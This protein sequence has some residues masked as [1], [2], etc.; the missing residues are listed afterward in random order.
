MSDKKNDDYVVPMPGQ[1]YE[2]K[3]APSEASSQ[4]PMS[5]HSDRPSP[6]AAGLSNSSTASILGYCLASIS[7]TVVN[8]YIV[9]GSEW[10]LMFL[11][12]AIQSVVCIIA[13]LVCQQMGLLTLERFDVEQAKKWFPIS[14]LL[15]AQIYTGGKALQFLSVPVFTIFKN[16]TIIVIAYGEVLLSGGRVTPLVLFSF[17]LMVFSSMVAAWAD[18]KAATSPDTHPS[19]A[20]DALKTLNAGYAWMFAN[21][22][23]SAAYVLGRGRMIKKLKTKDWDTTFYNNLLSIP[24]LII[25]SLLVEDW[26]SAN[27]ARNF[28]EETRRSLVVGM[29]YSGLGAVGISYASAWC[30]RATSSTTYSMVGALNKL[31]IAISGFIFFNAPVTVGG[32]SA[33]LIAFV[34]GIVYA[35]AKIREKEMAKM[36]LPT[37]K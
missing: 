7:M 25:C 4:G 30:Q 11:Y 5:Q 2:L 10:N 22:F 27:L 8:K 31:P 34:S 36:S 20:S 16:L 1:G 32:V 15:V 23:C 9:S 37:A 6:P 19:E 14:V 26:S 29:V 21:V 28:P 18:V 13:V 17:G 12:L 35:W 3:R 24:V 33:I